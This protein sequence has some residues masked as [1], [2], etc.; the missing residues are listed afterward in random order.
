MKIQYTGLR[1]RLKCSAFQ[2]AGPPAGGFLSAGWGSEP[3]VQLPR[4]DT[5]YKAETAWEMPWGSFHPQ[6]DHRILQ[7][8]A[9]RTCQ[10]EGEP[11]NPW[12]S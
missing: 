5:S 7:D 9:P 8:P 11:S 3:T 6:A 1:T 4:G 2:A 10:K 12:Q